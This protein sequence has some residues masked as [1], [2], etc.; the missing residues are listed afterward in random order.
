MSNIPFMINLGLFRYPENIQLQNTQFS[1]KT[2]KSIVLEFNDKS[3]C[4]KHGFSD[5]SQIFERDDIFYEV[6]EMG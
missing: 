4:E 5:M 3:S 1:N 2:L 6:K